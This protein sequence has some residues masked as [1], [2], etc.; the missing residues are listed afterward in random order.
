M[1]EHLSGFE[2]GPCHGV[3]RPPVLGYLKFISKLVADRSIAIAVPPVWNKLPPALP[4][5]GLSD[6]SYELTKTKGCRDPF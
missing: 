5:L 2:K 4:H 1:T 3:M 6:P